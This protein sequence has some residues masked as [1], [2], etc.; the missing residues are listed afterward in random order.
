MDEFQGK[1]PAPRARRPLKFII[2]GVVIVGAIIY[3]I[4]SSLNASVQYFLTVDEV[5]SKSS[6]G[7]LDGRNIR[8]S[9]AVLGETIAYDIDNLVLSFTIAH[10]PADNQLL[11]DEGG[12]AQ[13]LHNAVTDS[14]RSQM[15]VVYTGPIPDLLQ[16]EAQA[17]LTGEMLPNGTFQADEILLKCP[18][19]Y[20]GSVPEQIELES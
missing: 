16:N 19:K 5:V 14:T 1:D 6:L 18:T 4:I 7:E 9:G 15:E 2:G 12:L 13:A 10:V 20:E 8:V 11:A 17:I 3:L